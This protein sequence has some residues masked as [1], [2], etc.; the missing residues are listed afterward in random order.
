MF[1]LLLAGCENEFTPKAPYVERIVVFSVLDPTADY[2]VVRLESTYDTELDDPSKRIGERVIDSARVTIADDR[3]SYLLHDTL[4]ALPDGNSK[5]VWI[6]YDLKPREGAEYTMTV[7]VPGFD[8]ITATTQVP[9]RTY[10]QV[11]GTAG[12]ARLIA[13][14]ETAY[15]PSAFFL[16]L[17]VVGE[18]T[19]GGQQVDVR[20][21]VPLTLTLDPADYIYPEPT[22][23]SV[24]L[25]P[26]GNVVA[27]HDDL[28]D[29]DGV[30]GRFLVGTGYSL[31]RYV[32]SYYK[33]VRG[34]DDPVS[35]RQDLPDVTNVKGG[36][37]IFGAIFVD[38]VRVSYSSVVTQ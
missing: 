8:R 3:R 7:L 24:A 23:Q 27:I 1:L 26:R 29:M 31:D 36:A 35:V 20:R 12:G 16:R 11:Q 34:F 18:R 13:Q 22:R 30:S 38:S 28:A 17:W 9:S 19:D 10:V 6:S 21:E 25:F 14:D 37:G 33:L 4:I 5:R 2:Q 15:P 32:Y